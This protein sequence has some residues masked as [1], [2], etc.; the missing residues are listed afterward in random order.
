MRKLLKASI[1][2]VVV[3][4]GGCASNAQTFWT[5]HNQYRFDNEASLNGVAGVRLDG[6][7]FMP[8]TQVVIFPRTPYYEEKLLKGRLS[9][10]EWSLTHKT[11][12]SLSGG[13]SLPRLPEASWIMVAVVPTAPSSSSSWV[14]VRSAKTRA[15]INDEVFLYASSSHARLWDTLSFVD[16]HDWQISRSSQTWISTPQF[17]LPWG[18]KGDK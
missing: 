5:Q 10:R 13:Y 15:S 16:Q 18:A 12:C 9:Q 11:T 2:I 7:A 4:L 17:V 3:C 8:C 1:F 6:G 14:M